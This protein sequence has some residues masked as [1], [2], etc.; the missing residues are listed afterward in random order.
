MTDKIFPVTGPVWR[1][2]PTAPPQSG[3]TRTTCAL[4]SADYCAP[5]QIIFTYL[6]YLLAWKVM[7]LEHS[8]LVCKLHL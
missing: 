3:Y 8:L 1:L 2:M 5:L 4:A 7:L 6:L